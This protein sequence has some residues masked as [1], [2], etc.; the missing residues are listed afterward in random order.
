MP[1]QAGNNNHY[2]H[3]IGGDHI[4]IEA[5][6]ENNFMPVAEDI[7]SHIKEATLISLCSPQ[8]PNRYYF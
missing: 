3:F 5:K 7:R 8:N 6:A 1:Y 4:V 2:T